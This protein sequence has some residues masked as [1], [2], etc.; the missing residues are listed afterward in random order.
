VKLISGRPRS[1]GLLLALTLLVAVLALSCGGEKVQSKWR[2]REI[3]L[4]GIPD[5]W[6]GARTYIESPNIA[7]GVMNDE[8]YLYISL[9]TPVRSVATR[10]LNQGLT[11]W[12]EPKDRGNRVF[13]VMCPMGMAGFDLG[14]RPAARP[15]GE[16][17]GPGA[18]TGS[19]AD[20]RSRDRR[21]RDAAGA[22]AAEDPGR[23]KELIKNAAT[24]LEILGP[25][26]D[27]TAIL[28]N[29]GTQGVEVAMAYRDG[30]FG[31]ELRVPLAINDDR[32][33]GIGGDREKPIRVGFETPE[34]KREETRRNMPDRRP[35]G[36]DMGGDMGGPGGGMPPGGMDGGGMRGGMRGES[37]Q[38]IKVWISVTLAT[39]PGG[40][41]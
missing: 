32:D 40:E 27:D 39:G 22:D 31:Y 35:P 19:G 23:I 24:R 18:D 6:H 10:F 11:V 3:V 37:L 7:L 1:G 21:G 8:I 38:A 12:F 15:G 13:G 26:E 34:I 28:L 2:D 41:E 36:G 5:E 29:D 9:A 14:G 30:N 33:Y 16:T 4:D 20:M 25:D 17:G